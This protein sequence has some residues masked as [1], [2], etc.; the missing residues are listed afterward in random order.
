MWSFLKSTNA[1]GVK[2]HRRKHPGAVSAAGR[3]G[4]TV[5]GGV[6]GF[7]SGQI[8][9]GSHIDCRNEQIWLCRLGFRGRAVVTN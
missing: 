9:V 3:S 4:I 5:F 2:L 8:Y 7:A 6:V 1:H